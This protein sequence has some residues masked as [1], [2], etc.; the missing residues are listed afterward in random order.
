MLTH[1]AATRRVTAIRAIGRW[2]LSRCLAMR[3]EVEL[4]KLTTNSTWQ[5]L[6]TI[7]CYVNGY[8]TDPRCTAGTYWFLIDKMEDIK[9][10][11]SL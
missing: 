1:L 3:C 2:L 10:N 5:K 6:A 4:D 9:A 8:Y 7:N 11:V